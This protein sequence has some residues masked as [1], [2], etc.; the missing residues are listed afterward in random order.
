MCAKSLL[1]CLILCNTVDETVACLGPLSMRLSRQVY[2]SG[3]PCPP[4]GDQPD[5]GIKPVYLM[6][7]ALSGISLPQ[8]PLGKLLNYENM[9]IHYRR[10]GKYRTKI[11]IVLLYITISLK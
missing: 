7:P 5:L 9:I 8:V 6:S 11:H 3:L 4:P 2:W 10:L 1:S